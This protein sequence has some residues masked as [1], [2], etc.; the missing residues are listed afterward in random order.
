MQIPKYLYQTWNS[1]HITLSL[2]SLKL[3]NFKRQ[4][5]KYLSIY[6]DNTLELN[7]T[8]LKTKYAC[9]SD[10]SFLVIPI[11][12]GLRCKCWSLCGSQKVS[13]DPYDIRKSHLSPPVSTRGL[14]DSDMSELDFDDGIGVVSGQCELDGR[15]VSVSR[16]LRCH[17]A[18]FCGLCHV[19]VCVLSPV[20]VHLTLFVVTLPGLLIVRMYHI[21]RCAIFMSSCVIVPKV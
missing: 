6:I 2:L 11:T 1:L 8:F 7:R 12:V 14:S 19:A 9:S 18:S 10:S 21:A 4:F 3:R 20:S 17:I 5:K 16:P 13:Q 15:V